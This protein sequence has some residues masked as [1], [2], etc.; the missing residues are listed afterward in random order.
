MVYGSQFLFPPEIVI[1]EASRKKRKSETTLL[2][3]VSHIA[4]SSSKG[5]QQDPSTSNIY[6]PSKGWK[7]QKTGHQPST[8]FFSSTSASSVMDQNPSGEEG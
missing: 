7:K 1:V 3:Q 6:S 8:T 5:Q 4:L 2:I